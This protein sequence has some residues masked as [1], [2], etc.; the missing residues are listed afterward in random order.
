MFTR[1][2]IRVFTQNEILDTRIMT[3]LFVDKGYSKRTSCPKSFE[4]LFL[5]LKS[6]IQMETKFSVLFH[7][8][9]NIAKNQKLITIYVR[10]TVNGGR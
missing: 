9:K 4:K 7:G 3:E 10:I 8:K 6:G 5:T 1:V 2:L